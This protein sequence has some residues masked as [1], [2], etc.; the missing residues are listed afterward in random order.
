MGKSL[1]FVGLS[2]P[3]WEWQLDKSSLQ[4]R[5]PGAM[6]IMLSTLAL[7]APPGSLL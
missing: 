7:L 2:F 6:T 3:T 1:T 4:T 5:Q